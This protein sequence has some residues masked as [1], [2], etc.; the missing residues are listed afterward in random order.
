[1]AYSSLV[2]YKKDNNGDIEIQ[3]TWRDSYMKCAML[4]SEVKAEWL[5]EAD[6]WYRLDLVD[7]NE[8]IVSSKILKAEDDLRLGLVI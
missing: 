8:Q 3:D 7:S 4:F 2:L 5:S 6:S 1:M